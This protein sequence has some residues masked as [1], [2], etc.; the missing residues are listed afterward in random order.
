MT[1]PQSESQITWPSRFTRVPRFDLDKPSVPIH[2][3]SYTWNLHGVP[4]DIGQNVD[5][6]KM[7]QSI[8]ESLKELALGISQTESYR[9]SSVVI[10][11]FSPEHYSVTRLIPVHIRS[12]DEHFVATFFDAN[13]STSGETEEEAFSNLKDLILEIFSYLDSA[14]SEQLGPEPLRQI[15]VLREFIRSY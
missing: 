8:S 1:P 6:G 2:F 15:A 13:I 11:T 14:D 3:T 10:A 9:Q 12:A 5:L 4:I 7:L